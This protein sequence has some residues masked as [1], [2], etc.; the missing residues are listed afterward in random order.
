MPDDLSV[1]GHRVSFTGYLKL[2]IS[3]ILITAELVLKIKKMQRVF[4]N[5]KEKSLLKVG[6]NVQ[7]FDSI[8]YKCIYFEMT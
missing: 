7:P 4:M 8:Q 2:R 3:E 1:T 5:R 6:L